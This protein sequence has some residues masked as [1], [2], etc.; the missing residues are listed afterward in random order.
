MSADPFYN[1]VIPASVPDARL[2]DFNIYDYGGADPFEKIHEMHRASV[3]ELFWT[4]NNG[5]HW[6]ALGAKAIAEIS[7]DNTRF[8]SIRPIVPDSQNLAEPIFIPLTS[9]PPLHAGYRSVVAPLFMPKHIASLEEGLNSYAD[10]VA[11]RIKARGE[12]EF[13]ADVANEV[14]IVV[15]LKFLGLPI[16][17]RW[18]LLDLAATV[19]RPETGT[20]RDDPIKKLMDYLRP[21]LESRFAN[22]GDD[23][24]SQIVRQ[25]IDGAP[26]TPDIMIRLT[27]SILLGGLE[28]TTSS[29]GFITRHL[30]LHPDARRH[31]REH[32]ETMR[33]AVEEFLRRF[34][35]AT[36]GRQ[37]TADMEFRDVRMRKGEHIVWSTA[38]YNLDARQF[39]E[40]MKVDFSRKGNHS[41]FGI[42]IHF[43][44]GAFLA[45]MELG[46][47]L[48]QWLA[49]IPN[50]HI[51]PGSI[52]RYRTGL[53]MS[54]VN[55]PLAIDAD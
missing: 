48:R 38:M 10:E 20:H 37:V 51:L 26:L 44:L 11:L 29:L 46:I 30:A 3:P 15:F 31:L 39:A 19:V 45:R 1:P 4:R 53:T 28:T 6:I 24:I 42:G 32:P 22:P 5:G 43:C 21:F 47:F 49:H 41:S 52:L 33:G 18:E 13:M 27:M 34:A 54:L 9:D 23:I 17:D 7:A 14:P 55:L 36:T 40:P 50:F 12:C 2:H 25:K 8:S 35:P 16:G